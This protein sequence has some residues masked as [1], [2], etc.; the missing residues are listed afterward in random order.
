MPQILTSRP[1]DQHQR[2]RQPWTCATQV[3]RRVDGT[4]YGH[5]LILFGSL[6]QS[7]KTETVAVTGSVPQDPAGGEGDAEA[8]RGDLARLRE[9]FYG[10]LTARADAQFELVDALLCADGPGAVVGRSVAGPGALPRA[11]RSLRW[12]QPRVYRDRRPAPRPAA[13]AGRDRIVLAADVSPWRRP[14]AETSGRA[15][16]GSGARATRTRGSCSTPVTTDGVM[17]RS[18][19]APAGAGVGSASRGS[20][21]RARA[22]SCW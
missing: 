21:G 12:P 16:P 15:G 7:S 19:S 11:R 5:R 20:A 4:W 10:F 13:A 22:I 6:P 2:S 18:V 14:D 1:A 8:R 9:V 3:R 17:G